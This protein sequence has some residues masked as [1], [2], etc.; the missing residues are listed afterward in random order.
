[1][2][3]LL[4]HVRPIFIVF[5]GLDLGTDTTSSCA[6]PQLNKSNCIRSSI[7]LSP[8]TN[9]FYAILKGDYKLIFASFDADVSCG[10]L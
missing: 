4:L 8:D 3:S 7:S 5:I 10:N 2:L 1:M 9:R 6:T